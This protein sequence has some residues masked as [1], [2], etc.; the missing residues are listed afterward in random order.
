M[1]H[2]TL[3]RSCARSGIVGAVLILG[4]VSLA[5][6]GSSERLT[7]QQPPPAP[8]A[9][10]VEVGTEIRTEAG[11]RRRL[12]LPDG[13]VLYVNEKSSVKLMAKRRLALTSGEIFVETPGKDGQ[14][15][16]VVQTPKREISGHA[17]RFAAR[18]AEDGTGIVELD[19][20]DRA[21]AAAFAAEPTDA[22]ILWDRAQN[23]RQ[24]GKRP[25]ADKLV[26]LLADGTWQPRF[27]ALQAQAR[28]HLEG[29]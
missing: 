27:Q 17:A 29:R 19:L 8:P 13:S 2:P 3:L 23:L 5:A 12:L 28:W 16:L 25:E 24:A 20:A 15:S 6:E 1:S 21:F 7:S 26:R 9:K 18:V 22:Q 4:V 10:A 11:Q 14:E